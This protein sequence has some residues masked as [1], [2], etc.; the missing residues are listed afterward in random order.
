[1]WSQGVHAIQKR[2]WHA[3]TQW[4]SQRRKR[5]DTRRAWRQMA[6][7]LSPKGKYWILEY[8][9]AL[10]LLWAGTTAFHSDSAQLIPFIADDKKSCS[11][12]ISAF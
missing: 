12:D 8:K 6:S 9:N 2:A 5:G 1:M 3:G 10:E 4:M 7:Y 11:P